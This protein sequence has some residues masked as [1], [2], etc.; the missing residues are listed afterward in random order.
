MGVTTLREKLKS[1]DSA[2]S[3]FSCDAAGFCCEGS[4]IHSYCILSM[5]QTC[6][7][8]LSAQVLENVSLH[9][10]APEKNVSKK[11]LTNVSLQPHVAHILSI[12]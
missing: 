2:T 8:V 3:R 1:P 5:R 7:Y 12:E 11:T 6:S 4:F 9:L 10:W